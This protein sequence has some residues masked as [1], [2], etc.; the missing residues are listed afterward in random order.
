M[1]DVI[2]LSLSAPVRTEKKKKVFRVTD[3]GAEVWGSRGCGYEEYSLL[4][5]G[6]VYFA[7]DPSAS[8]FKFL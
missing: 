2:Q 6:A 1:S 3:Y 7:K 4:R 5:R 8:I